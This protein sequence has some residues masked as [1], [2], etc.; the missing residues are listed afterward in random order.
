[1]VLSNQKQ[2]KVLNNKRSDTLVVNMSF[3]KKVE[4][5]CYYMNSTFLVNYKSEYRGRIE[6]S[7][8]QG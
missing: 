8:K 6:W 5:S 2:F 3:F 1:M 7:G 4:F